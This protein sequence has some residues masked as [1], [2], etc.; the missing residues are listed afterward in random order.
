MDMVNILNLLIYWFIFLKL[1]VLM[2]VFIFVW[3][4]KCMIYVL[5]L[6]CEVK[7]FVI[8]FCWGC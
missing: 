6:W 4:C 5:F 2:R 8:N 1:V 7:V 3:E